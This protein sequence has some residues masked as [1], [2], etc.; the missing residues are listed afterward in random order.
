MTNFTADE[1]ETQMHDTLIRKEQMQELCKRHDDQIFDII[2]NVT[3]AYVRKWSPS[4]ADY[5]QRVAVEGKRLNINPSSTSWQ[6]ADNF[7]RMY[8]ELDKQYNAVLH[9]QLAE[10]KTK[11]KLY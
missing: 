7:K 6:K 11:K 1:I 9:I 8:N 3:E 5:M 4:I 2:Y 10:L